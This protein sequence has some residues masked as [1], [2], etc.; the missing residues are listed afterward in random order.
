MIAIGLTTPE[1]LRSQCIT[2]LKVHDKVT[3]S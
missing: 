3:V 2:K 1:V